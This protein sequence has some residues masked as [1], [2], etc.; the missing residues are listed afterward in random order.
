MAT[1]TLD[2]IPEPNAK[3]LDDGQTPTIK[4]NGKDYPIP[5]LAP[6]QNRVV[7]PALLRLRG[8]MKQMEGLRSLQTFDGETMTEAQFDDLT[9]VVFMGL[10]RAHPDIR[11]DAFDEVPCS[12]VDMIMAMVVV[13]QQAMGM[14]PGQKGDDNSADL[15]EDVQK[16]QTGIQLS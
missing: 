3:F 13:S 14:K 4:W 16:P 5:L 10:K 2:T 12:M 1:T 8:V 11:K 7:M 6:R 9:N 15:G